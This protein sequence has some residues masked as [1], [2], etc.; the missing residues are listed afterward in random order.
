MYSGVEMDGVL[1]ATISLC[2]CKLLCS[3]LYLPAF[4]DSM[5][6][7]SLCCSCLLLFTDISSTAFLAYLWCAAPRPGSFQPSSDV[8]ALRIMLFLGSTYGVVLMLTPLLVAV[9]VLV[10]LLWP[11]EAAATLD[12]SGESANETQ[13]SGLGSTVLVMDREPWETESGKVDK[14]ETRGIFLKFL[15]AVGFLGCLLLWGMSG[16]Y[17]ESSWRQDQPVVREC[18]DRGGS[19]SACLPCLLNT[20]SPM[21]G[22]LSRVLGG[23]LLLLGLTGSLC[24]LLMKLSQLPLLISQTNKLHISRDKDVTSTLHLRALSVKVHRSRDSGKE[25]RNSGLTKMLERTPNHNASVDSKTKANSC[26][27]Q[28]SQLG[29]H[30]QPWPHGNPV[31]LSGQTGLADS[32]KLQ[33]ESKLL[34]LLPQTELPLKGVK[35]ARSTGQAPHPHEK[36]LWRPLKESPCL[37]GDLMT[38]LVCGLL[39]CAFPTVLS[40]NILLVSNLDTLAAYAVKHLLIP[41][42]SK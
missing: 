26:A 5:S 13:K 20:S 37:R 36:R 12:T 4:K 41:S 34:V 25:Q 14:R 1:E 33:S 22:Q 27:N 7:V 32:C 15:K 11:Q 38:G 23:I 10:R 9:E 31:P 6:S 24:L 28:S 40:T 2:G 39:V 42:H 17:A 35:V 16:T 30:G 3:L 21:T 18:L 8:I 29:Y 19:L